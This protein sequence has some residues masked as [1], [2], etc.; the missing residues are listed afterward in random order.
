MPAHGIELAGSG[1]FRD[2]KAA[3]PVHDVETAGMM[4]LVAGQNLFPSAELRAAVLPPMSS[5][6]RNAPRQPSP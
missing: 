3:N 6:C 2:P 5:D 1:R 4:T